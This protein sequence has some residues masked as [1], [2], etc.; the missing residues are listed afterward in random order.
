M[1][2]RVWIMTLLEY[3][4]GKATIIKSFSKPAKESDVKFKTKE[5]I[6]KIEV[7]KSSGEVD[8]FG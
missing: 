7:N 4:N 1:P 8:M 2:I 6:S 5:P 3:S